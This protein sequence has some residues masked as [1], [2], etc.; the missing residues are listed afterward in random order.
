[1]AV[2]SDCGP[3]DPRVDADLEDF[4]N[5]DP[6]VKFT[7]DDATG[8]PRGAGVALDVL[9][10]NDALSEQLALE[11]ALRAKRKQIFDDKQP[12]YSQA[13]NP[14]RIPQ[15]LFRSLQRYTNVPFYQW[16]R[17]IEDGLDDVELAT[18]GPL[19][20]LREVSR[21]L[22]G[23]GRL[24]NNRNE[25]QQVQ[26]LLEERLNDPKSAAALQA[27]LPKQVVEAANQLE[28]VYQRYFSA[29]GFAKEDI[30]D[31]FKTFR[32]I[33]ERDG[34][35]KSF[36]MQARIPKIM[37]NLSQEF[38]TGE[39]MLDAREWDFYAIGERLIRADARIRHLGPS[40]N[41]IKAQRDG[42]EADG[43]VSRELLN[44]FDTY[45]D[46]VRHAP[47]HWQMAFGRFTNK[48]TS[49]LLGKTLPPDQIPDVVPLFLSTNYYANMAWNTGTAIRNFMQ[50]LITSYPILGEQFTW[51]GYKAAIR[52][53][54]NSKDLE[55]YAKL[56]VITREVE[57]LQASAIRE[58]MSHSR[59]PGGSDAAKF[60]EKFQEAGW[61]MFRSA[62]NTNRIMSYQGMVDRATH[63][64]NQFVKGKISWDQFH[65]LSK[66]DHMDPTDG[67]ISQQIRN[68]IQGGGDVEQGAH[69][70]GLQFTRHTQFVYR[71]GNNPY[72]MQGTVGRLFGQYGT[73]PAW[74]ASYM[75]N[76]V[77]RGSMPNRVTALGRWSA[78]NAAVLYAGSEVFGVEMSRQAFFAPLGYTGGPFVELGQQALAAS[79]VA[80][81]STDPIDKINAGRL[82][83]GYQQVVPFVPWGAMRNGKGAWDAAVNDDWKTASKRFLGF[84]PVEGE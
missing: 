59:A 3:G 54:R 73:W 75:G 44:Y 21:G 43:T 28:G 63:Y 50:P 81:G 19:K 83:N 55:R 56:G 76:L 49:R 48:V 65:K 67:P 22:K 1:M 11:A 74:Y 9:S 8:K 29:Q 68:L 12:W 25:R 72:V 32:S 64:G 51:S 39:I 6:E 42:F 20:E 35:Y 78:A 33:R 58:A 69:L 47:D 23:S 17:R 66:L 36:G 34:D 52:A 26:R 77:F 37:K 40:W 10:D 60:W 53:G 80:A 31:F 15:E 57:P 46:Q 71:R 62:E 70:M 84:Q 2:P 24:G 13:V 27:K 16:F 14:V 82:V 4:V 5:W 38:K 18:S 45:V 41:L 7:P 61:F 30:E 79:Q